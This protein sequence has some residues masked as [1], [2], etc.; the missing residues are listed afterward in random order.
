MSI[1][2]ISTLVQSQFPDF[3]KEDGRNFLAFM[4][5]YYEWMESEGQMTDAIRNLESWHD[6][7]TTTDDFIDYF[8][9]KLLPSVPIDVVA[10][11]KLMAKY[12]KEFN[13]SRGTLASYKLMFRAIYNEDVE[14]NYPSEEILKVSHGDWRIDQYLV[15]QFNHENY[16]YIGKTIKGIESH[17]EAFVE[18]VIGGVL[19]GRHLHQLILSNIKGE[20]KHLE[21]IYLKSDTSLS[22]HT[23]V[24][25]SGISDVSIDYSGGGYVPGDVVNLISSHSGNSGKVIIGKIDNFGGVLSIAIANGGSGYI[26][27]DNPGTTIDWIGDD[28]GSVQAGFTINTSDLINTLPI[29]TAKDTIGTETIFGANAPIITQTDNTLLTASTFANTVLGQTNYGFREESETDEDKDYHDHESATLQ[30][31]NSMWSSPGNHTFQVGQKL[32]GV[33]GAN[34]IVKFIGTDTGGTID[35]IVDGYKNWDANTPEAV[36]LNTIG[37]GTSMGNVSQWT[38]NTIGGHI[39]DITGSYTPTLN[40]EIVGSTSNASGIVR[41]IIDSDTVVVTANTTANVSS[42]F[43]TGPMKSYIAGEDLHLVDNATVIGTAT[44]STANTQTEGIYTTLG[45]SFL[46]KTVNVGTIDSFSNKSDG[47]GY[48][49]APEIVI[50]SNSTATLGIG[51]TYL[52]LESSDD[53]W[54][55]GNSQITVLQAGDKVSQANTGATGQVMEMVS[56]LD[57]DNYPNVMVIR[58]FQDINQR[59]PGNVNWSENDGIDLT[60]YDTSHTYGD[61]LGDQ[62]TPAGSGQ[63]HVTIV[64]D[65]GVLGKNAEITADVGSNGTINQLRVIDSGFSYKQ[66]EQVIIESSGRP[67]SIHAEGT[68]TLRG[69]A[70]AEGYYVSSRSH[71]S[72]KRGHIY[73]GKYYQ[74]YSYELISPISLARYRD[75]ALKLCHPAG[76]AL[77]SR[78]KVSSEAPMNVSA[79]S[80]TVIMK[81]AT[82]YVT[83]SRPQHSGTISITNNSLNVTGTNLSTD[84]ADGDFIIIETGNDKNL[85]W[86]TELNK[87]ESGTSANLAQMWTYGDVVNANI[88]FANTGTAHT[89]SRFDSLDAPYSNTSEFGNG[90]TMFIEILPRQY[91]PVILNSFNTND[92]TTANLVSLWLGANT[93]ITANAYY[94]TGSL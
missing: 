52:T 59:E 37:E 49:E 63:A 69:A 17:S 41:R 6:I 33:S 5:A 44:S 28:Q 64:D 83:L 18:D 56:M 76:Q 71:I 51:D 30:V 88:Y 23:S 8:F 20:F 32:Y 67:K 78:Y 27:S 24:I 60:F 40:D 73:D 84:I 3:Y 82:G 77:F 14:V 38:A 93:F 35:L 91:S 25:E 65:K 26:S 50:R 15:T 46:Y 81:K 2:K 36:H 57:Y 10:D 72:S 74:E 87:V 11:K 75:I 4:Q 31:A 80:D 85:F 48:E 45:E 68:I 29:M 7:S 53:N 12:V 34:A 19:N 70:N 86:L 58:V 42:Q 61:P 66:G 22:E 43:D 21:R 92:G 62:R 47:W 1:E 16:Q 94:T 79:T 54:S 90:S 9:R 13:Q 89:V 39:L 55:T